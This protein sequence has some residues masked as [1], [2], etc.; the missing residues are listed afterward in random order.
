MQQKQENK[1]I[2]FEGM[3]LQPQHFQQHN[4]YIEHLIQEKHTLLN[5]NR[6]GFTHLELDHS[7]LSVG[8][9]GISSAKGLFRDGTLFNIPND[10]NRPDPYSIPEGISNTTLYL[11]IPLC[12]H[13]SEA[14][15]CDLAKGD[16]AKRVRYHVEDMDVLDSLADSDQMTQVQIGSLAT[17]ILTEHDDL[18]AY[19]CLPIACIKESRSNFNITLDESF[20]T[21]CLDVHRFKFLG[22]LINEFHALLNHRA[23]MLAGRLTDTQQAGTAEIVDFML[24]QLVNRYEP[25]FHYLSH[26]RPLHPEQLFTILIQLMGEMTTFTSDN[27]RPI[28]P[29]PYKHEDLLATFNPVIKELRHGLSRVLEQN[30]TPIHLQAR[31]HGL[32]VGEIPVKELIKSCDFVLAVYAD[33][34]AEQLRSVFL[35][36]TKLAPVEQIQT[37]VSRALPGID[38]QPM[39]VSPRQI[40]Y[41]ANFTYFSLNTKHQLWKQLERSAGIAFHVGGNLPGLKL[42]LWAIKG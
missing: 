18:S 30:A 39:A 31:S 11:A 7:L 22:Q 34:P 35:S 20:L 3:F 36:V 4:R 41:H 10:D 15:R 38:L 32:W 8:K 6:W 16:S 25:L 13:S 5:K 33:M 26:K 29:P 21:T 28:E 23:E 27:R 1:V 40:P 12:H 9:I 17:R 24:L 19:S 37:L 14:E 42:E 2:W